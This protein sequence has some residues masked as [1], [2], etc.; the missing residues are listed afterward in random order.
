[1]AF[2][3]YRGSA[4]PT[5]AWSANS[6]AN[7]ALSNTDVDTNFY[8]LDAQK[9][10]IAG[11]TITGALTVT[12]NLTVN[13]TTTTVNSTTVS[14]DDKNIEL[15]SIA[16]PTDALADGG[17]ITLKGTTD[18]TFNWVNSTNAWTASVKLSAPT[19]V[20]TVATGTAPL[21]VASN[22]L[23]TNLNA[24][25]LDGQ[26]GAYYAAVSSIGNGSISVSIGTA[27]LTNNTVVWGTSTGFTANASSNSTY[28]LKVGPALTALAAF[29][30][31]AG[32]GFV[33][34]NGADTYSID[35]NT[36]LTSVGATSPVAST[37]GTAPTISMAAA[38]AS[39]DGYMTSTYAAKLDGIAA[40][41]QVNT[42]TSVAGKTGA[43]ALVKGDVGLGSVDN[44]ADSTKNVNYASSAGNAD[45][46]DGQHFAW[47][48]S[49]NAPTYLWGADANGSA[50]LAHRASMS[51]NY[52]SYAA[53]GASNNF[54]VR[55]TSPTI[56]LVDTDHGVT[57]RI[58]HNSNII[59]FLSNEGGWILQVDNAGNTT[60]SGNVTAYS[61]AR[62]KTD[63]Q[64]IGNAVEK[65]GT[66]TG[67]TYTRT[68]SG[69]R[70][71]GLIAQD[72]IKVLPEAVDDSGEH[73]SIAY[74]NV[75][76]LLI[77]AIK[78][79][80]AEIEELKRNK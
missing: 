59:G 5:V 34:K 22:T 19:L 6:A 78:E 51:V 38:T 73:M 10:D 11:G 36:Y 30:T 29:M 37:G 31:G 1:M 23:V 76:G 56:E 42:V 64:V 75:V 20:S 45:S 24:D 80:K 17:G 72:L 49:G 12:G 70:Q 35:T 15:G 61:D 57:K 69:Q 4:I 77:E 39:V 48:N 7:A 58:H 63:L 62:L 40:G 25:L 52:A 44:T 33:R 71:T 8:S 46:V 53:E 50:Y 60:A 41:A 66:L 55:G 2:L 47:S 26:D 65:V 28:D 18:K 9:L 79:L 3:K 54:Y 21:T 13:G 32:T 43:V 14:V 68:D 67:Y 27:A 74:G 16:S